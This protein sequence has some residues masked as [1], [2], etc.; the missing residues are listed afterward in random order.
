MIASTAITPIASLAIPLLLPDGS[1]IS[2]TR[3]AATTRIK[4]RNGRSRVFQCGCSCRTRCSP[5]VREPSLAIGDM[6]ACITASRV[7]DASPETDDIPGAHR[8]QPRRAENDQ[9]AC[10]IHVLGDPGQ[11]PPAGQ[12]YPDLLADG[13]AQAAVFGPQ[14]AG[15]RVTGHWHRRA[16]G[17]VPGQVPALQLGKHPAEQF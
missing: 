8:D 17:A 1:M 2:S 9:P 15:V 3:A 5:S 16:C 14:T 13:P 10:R 12:R 11:D 7:P 4:I 6:V